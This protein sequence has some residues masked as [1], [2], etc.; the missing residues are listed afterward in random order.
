MPQ[1]PFFL[2]FSLFL[3]QLISGHHHTVSSCLASVSAQSLYASQPKSSNSHSFSSFFWTSSYA[4]LQSVHIV[5][6]LFTLLIYF[7]S[8]CLFLLP[9]F[10]FSSFISLFCLSNLLCKYSSKLFMFFSCS[11]LI[12]SAVH[13]FLQLLLQDYLLLC[14]LPPWP[15]CIL[16]SPLFGQTSFHCDNQ[17]IQLLS[18]VLQILSVCSEGQ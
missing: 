12:S 15:T 8:Y 14:F 17:T 11:C 6:I 4:C 18:L 10:L 9:I 3:L 13:L 1:G 16:F 5:F 7:S 2:H